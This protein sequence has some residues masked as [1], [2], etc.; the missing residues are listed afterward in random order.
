LATTHFYKISEGRRTEFQALRTYRHGTGSEII[1]KEPALD[2]EI[3][4]ALPDG[5]YA[6]NPML[7]ERLLQKEIKTPYYNA[8]RSEAYDYNRM[9][10]ADDSDDET[11]SHFS[12]DS[13]GL[14]RDGQW[15]SNE[16]G[17]RLPEFIVTKGEFI[18]GKGKGHNSH[19]TFHH[20]KITRSNRVTGIGTGKSQQ[21][22]YEV[23]WELTATEW[24]NKYSEFVAMKRF[25]EGIDYGYRR[26]KGHGYDIGV[27]VGARGSNV[28]LEDH[29][30][31]NFRPSN[32]TMSYEIDRLVTQEWSPAYLDDGPMLA[33]EVRGVDLPQGFSRNIPVKAAPTTKAIPK[34]K[35]RPEDCQWSIFSRSDESEFTEQDVEELRQYLYP[36]RQRGAS[37]STPEAEIAAMPDREITGERQH[38]MQPDDRKWAPMDVPK[39]KP[40]ARGRAA[41]TAMEIEERKQK[42]AQ[43][44]NAASQ[45]YHGGLGSAGSESE[46]VVTHESHG[47]DVVT[48][49]PVNYECQPCV[50]RQEKRELGPRLRASAIT[51]ETVGGPPETD[52][53]SS[54]I[55]LKNPHDPSRGPMS[56]ERVRLEA[57]GAFPSQDAIDECFGSPKKEHD[58]RCR[59]PHLSEQDVERHQQRLIPDE[60]ALG[61]CGPIE[62]EGKDVVVHTHPAD[63][64]DRHNNHRN[65][66]VAQFRKDFT[67]P[68]NPL[69][70][71]PWLS[72]HPKFWD[73]PGLMYL[74]RAQENQR[75]EGVPTV[76]DSSFYYWEAPGGRTKFRMLPSNTADVGEYESRNRHDAKAFER[77]QRIVRVK[78]AG[79][80]DC[81][82]TRRLSQAYAE[83][84]LSIPQQRYAQPQFDFCT[85]HNCK[86][87]IFHP[88]EDTNVH[89]NR[90]KFCSLACMNQWMESADLIMEEEEFDRIDMNFFYAEWI[91]AARLARMFSR[92]DTFTMVPRHLLYCA[93]MK[94][95]EFL[96]QVKILYQHHLADMRANEARVSRS[97]ADT[98]FLG[99]RCHTCFA[100]ML[101]AWKH[102]P[103]CENS[104]DRLGCRN[105]F[106]KIGPED[107]MCSY[108]LYNNACWPLRGVR[109]PD[110]L[111]PKAFVLPDSDCEES[112]VEGA[113]GSHMVEGR[114]SPAAA[115]A[116]EASD[117]SVVVHHV[118]K[119]YLLPQHESNVISASPDEA[120]AQQM[121]LWVADWG[122]AR[123]CGLLFDHEVELG[124]KNDHPG[125]CPVLSF[126]PVWIVKRIAE[127][128]ATRSLAE[129]D[130][131][132]MS[133]KVKF[134]NLRA[135]VGFVSKWC[136]SP[137]RPFPDIFDFAG[138]L[139]TPPEKRT[140]HQENSLDAAGYCYF[141]PEVTD[142]DH[143][144]FSTSYNGLNQNFAVPMLF[145]AD[146]T[147]EDP[148]AARSS[149]E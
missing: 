78:M 119:H 123:D 35:P 27:V 1:F 96:F 64:T 76:A 83:R 132:M 116:V 128:T 13:D 84:Y 82:A 29:I 25:Q 138:I 110:E 111:G 30:T 106:E 8:D 54:D 121:Q 147:P 114:L 24:H 133:E 91:V 57:R 23:D 34:P 11:C 44:F 125:C 108:C 101:D 75:V 31:E 12:V 21:Q 143:L 59:F 9:L 131:L 40:K 100:A 117:T 28:P 134:N 140:A 16:L 109:S 14:D 66:I 136:P 33:R 77:A 3:A 144:H 47:F 67:D 120:L 61:P 39:T 92:G 60:V 112:A 62:S 56:L 17:K 73:N 129:V 55:R 99:R 122:L 68:Y 53:P 45:G 135:R 118:I 2:P 97:P 105:C 126:D 70:Q 90:A 41:I 145:D 19:R 141:L 50:T 7:T 69:E 148:N 85:M 43:A 124:I 6:V 49:V 89:L 137:T 46:F 63:T 22:P 32:R 26:G 130:R 98:R 113:L 146:T 74:L 104:F 5:T 4:E 115:Y 80:A 86:R 10:N 102:C 48:H 51:T 81:V 36:N 58:K 20:V 65:L 15:F 127:R 94:W 71:F 72:E 95:S 103:I 18:G 42:A 88:V 142:L 107:R 87:P 38:G 139:M 149:W 37:S 93:P 79:D 52:E